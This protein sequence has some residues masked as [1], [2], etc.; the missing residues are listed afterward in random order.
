MKVVI[1]RPE[2]FSSMRTFTTHNTITVKE[3]FEMFHNATHT[4]EGKWKVN[5]RSRVITTLKSTDNG[6]NTQSMSGIVSFDNRDGY[7][8]INAYPISD[9]RYALMSWKAQMENIRIK[10]LYEFLLKESKSN[11]DTKV[12]F[13]RPSGLSNLSYIESKNER[14]YVPIDMVYKEYY[15]PSEWNGSSATNALKYL[16]II[17]PRYIKE[18]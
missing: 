4:P 6:T 15:M 18:G 1:N 14:A 17:C 7:M 5:T 12:F 3:F 13:T 16:N 11:P 2:E 10:H 8:V 9:R